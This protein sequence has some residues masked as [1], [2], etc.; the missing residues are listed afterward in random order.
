MGKHKYI[1]WNKPKPKRTGVGGKSY[2]RKKDKTV[3]KLIQIRVTE[4]EFF[5]LK[6]LALDLKL[7][8]GALG[9]KLMMGYV[10]KK[11]GSTVG[12]F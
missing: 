11:D 3:Y 12:K 7:S 1:P 10:P 9:R 5:E 4:E 8:L 2:M 6:Q